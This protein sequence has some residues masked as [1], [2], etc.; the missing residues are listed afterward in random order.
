MNELPESEQINFIR[1]GYFLISVM[2]D[3]KLR[4]LK[5]FLLRRAMVAVYFLCDL[6][7]DLFSDVQNE[8]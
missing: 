4:V 2:L 1:T 5:E 6:P 8:F 3:N 7:T